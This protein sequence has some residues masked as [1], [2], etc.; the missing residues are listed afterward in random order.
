MVKA[1]IQSV[2]GDEF[3]AGSVS[4]E[5]IPIDFVK[6]FAKEHPEEAA[7]IFGGT[8]ELHT[9]L[10]S[11]FA[12]DTEKSSFAVKDGADY[13][14]LVWDKPLSDQGDRVKKLLKSSEVI[15]FVVSVSMPNA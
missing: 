9:A 14:S 10:Q 4:M 1:H 11:N 8:N 7:A 2:L 13:V 5:T 6:G 12:I 15:V 3:E